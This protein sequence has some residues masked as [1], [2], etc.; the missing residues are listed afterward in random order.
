M[1][2]SDREIY[3]AGRGKH[4]VVSPYHRTLLPLAAFQSSTDC[5]GVKGDSGGMSHG[6]FFLSHPGDGVFTWHCAKAAAC[7]TDSHRIFPCLRPGLWLLLLKKG[8]KGKK[9]K[10]PETMNDNDGIT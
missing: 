3:S 10:K 1:T 6:F 4:R 9:K 2:T 5:F 7:W 8:K